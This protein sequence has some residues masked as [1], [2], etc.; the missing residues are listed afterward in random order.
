MSTITFKRINP[1]SEEKTVVL[2]RI[3]YWE[4][5]GDGTRIFLDNGKEIQVGNY[6]HEV[7]EMFM[8]ATN[9]KTS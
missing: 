4:R 2:E 5:A 1:Y 8:K 3:V 9:A 6:P 7:Q